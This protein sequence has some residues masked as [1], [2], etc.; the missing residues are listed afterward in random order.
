[1]RIISGLHRGR[2]LAAPEG[3]SIRP[4][5]D[6]ARETLFNILVHNPWGPD[7]GAVLPDAIVL[8]ACCGTGACGL[9]ALSRGAKFCTF[10]D[11]GD[12]ALASA[13]YNIARLDEERRC[14]VQRADIRRP[15]RA[16]RPAT[17]VFLDPPYGDDLEQKA[18]PALAATGWL[19]PGTVVV[20]E[21]PGPFEIPPG[22]ALLDLRGIGR[23]V[24]TILRYA[25]QP[26]E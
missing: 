25:P 15:P 19:A 14:R 26:T 10:L 22:F 13:R 5:S 8:D 9:E 6:R 4:T 1:M 23:A 24:I 3:D 18:L 11:N 20:V 16:P 12:A 7:D 17:L 2:S 21:T